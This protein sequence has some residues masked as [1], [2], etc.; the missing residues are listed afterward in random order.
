MPARRIST[1]AP[2]TPR[3][4]AA[5]FNHWKA[6]LPRL[7]ILT[8]FGLH[9]AEAL[10]QRAASIEAQTGDG[11]VVI[12]NADGTW[13]FKAGPSRSSSTTVS[14]WVTYRGVLDFLPSNFTGH[15]PDLVFARLLD[16]SRR[17]EKS[18]FETNA[19]HERRVADE[20]QKPLLGN[21]LVTDPLVFVLARVEAEYDANTQT[22]QLFAP[23]IRHDQLGRDRASASD[24]ARVNA[25][26]LQALSR[27]NDVNLYFD[28]LNDFT[29]RK[30]GYR[31]GFLAEVRLG[32]E[33]AK[34]LK[35][36][37]KASAVVELQAPYAKARLTRQIQTGLLDVLFFDPRTG[38]I[39]AKLSQQSLAEASRQVKV[40]QASSNQAAGARRVV[41][42]ESVDLL[43]TRFDAY[44][45]QVV[46]VVEQKWKELLDR[47][48]LSRGKA[49]RI[50]LAFRLG[51]DGHVSE[52]RTE[53]D[54]VGG[55]IGV[56][57]YRALADA[58][59]DGFGPWSS[60]MRQFLAAIS[61][62]MRFSFN[63]SGE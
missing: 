21:L 39:L 50:V 45:D 46:A 8:L 1:N 7:L 34:R 47:Q 61:R 40:V 18:E 35:A 25:Y 2:P 28:D 36:T 9:P 62:T 42:N 63:Y 37:I 54:T 6:I 33:E 29:L 20:L 59:K 24:L 60:E 17:L 56:L 23:A 22:M 10:S 38:Q 57:C 3:P 16:W 19:E 51:F 49:G 31:E 30:K 41:M 27:A 55:V 12:L 58:G 48:P 5:L 44:D 14:N 32:A 11:R 43:G 52:I 4:A 15:D 13:Q 26:G 53:E